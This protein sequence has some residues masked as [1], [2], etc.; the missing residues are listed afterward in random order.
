VKAN[1]KT[2]RNSKEA[3]GI[4]AQVLHWLVA[5]FIL[6]QFILGVYAASL[7]LSMAR[8][9][10]LSTHKSIGM[11]LLLLLLLRALWRWID[12][13]PP[14]PDSLARW[15]RRAALM[16]HAALYITPVLAILAGWLYASATGLSVNWFGRVLVPDLIAKNS[17]LAPLLK[18]LHQTLA[19]LLGLFLSAHIGAALRHALILKDG[20]LLR[21]LPIG[22]SRKN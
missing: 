11:T 2:L 19:V 21:M 17:Q 16:M 22:K 7:P 8:L 3:Y 15:E 1:V 12:P 18:T 9:Q 5:C 4:L 6:I 13:P 10:W 14:L 20:V